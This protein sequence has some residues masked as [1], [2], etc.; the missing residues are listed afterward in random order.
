M[1]LSTMSASTYSLTSFASCRPT[2]AV[3]RASS[4]SS[5]AT[6]LVVSDNEGLELSVVADFVLHT[7]NTQIITNCSKSDLTSA[8]SLDVR[9]KD[10]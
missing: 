6:S 7:E 10:N 1:L 2:F 5:V 3:M 8:S 9:N 4:M